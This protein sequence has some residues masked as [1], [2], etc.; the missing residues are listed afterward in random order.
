M[1]SPVTFSPHTSL[2]VRE[3]HGFARYFIFRYVP[4]YCYIL[5]VLVTLV[6][7]DQTDDIMLV[8]HQ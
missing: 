5:I 4:L 7:D 8:Q 3:V 1:S 2:R 6:Q